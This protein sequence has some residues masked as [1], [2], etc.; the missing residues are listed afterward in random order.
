MLYRL[1]YECLDNTFK[2]VKQGDEII[3]LVAT[4]NSYE[5]VQFYATVSEIT[6]DPF[7]L[8]FD[9]SEKQWKSKHEYDSSVVFSFDSASAI[10]NP[11]PAKFGKVADS[12]F[13]ALK[14]ICD[15]FIETNNLPE[16]INEILEKKPSTDVSIANSTNP[17]SEDIY[18]ICIK[19]QGS[20]LA[21]G[22][23]NWKIT[24]LGEVIA[25]LYHDG[26][27]VGL[28]APNYASS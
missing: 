14:N 13:K 16:V 3:L 4:N 2:K 22:T 18:K 19:M 28:A 26:Y 6:D 24:M 5:D 25:K 10:V 27:K 8:T 7:V 12:P 11:V 21:P 1:S 20:Y 23:R 9:I 17:S 15:Q